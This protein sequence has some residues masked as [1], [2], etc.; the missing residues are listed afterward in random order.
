MG[1]IDWD[2][3]EPS[4]VVSKRFPLQQSTSSVN[5]AVGILE[6]ATT[7]NFDV[8]SSMLAEFMKQLSLGGKCTKLLARSFDLSAAYR[9]LCVAPSSYTFSHICVYDQV[10]G[11]PRVFRQVCLPF[12]SWSAVNAFIKCAKCIQW[13]AAKCLFLPTT[14]DYDDF[15]VAST[16]ELATN[17]QSCL[18]LLLDLLGWKYDKEGP[19]ADTFSQSVVTFGVHFDLR[20]TNSSG[21]FNVCN[22]VKR[23]NDALA[24]IDATSMEG[25]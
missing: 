1:P 19:K 16:P 13:L 14:C 12:G 25:I 3:L 10:S 11:E 5:A 23:T 2:S 20:T 21:C 18:A 7:D 22:T 6:Q 4:S 8:K 9:Q 17:T 15:V 24:L